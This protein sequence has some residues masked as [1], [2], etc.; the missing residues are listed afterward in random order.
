M[1]GSFCSTQ[2][3]TSLA[4]WAAPTSSSHRIMAVG[5]VAAIEFP[6]LSTFADRRFG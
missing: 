3:P 2:T 5:L 6:A 1:V 4:H